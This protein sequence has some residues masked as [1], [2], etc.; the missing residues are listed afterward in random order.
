MTTSSA[1]IPSLEDPAGN[2]DALLRARAGLDGAEYVAWWTGDVY[3]QQPGADTRR[4]FGFVGFNVARAVA[5]DGGYDL[6]SREVAFYLD[7]RTRQIISRWHNPD[8]DSD[9]DV[10]HI[11]NDPVN[12]RFRLTMPWGPWRA[13]YTVLGRTVV[14]NLDIP[15]SAPSPL[16][17]SEWPDNS[18]DD[19]YRAMELFQFYAPRA[20]LLETDAPS[21]DCDISWVRTSPWLPWMRMGNRQGGLLF[22][23]R[24]SKLSGFDELPH[25]VRAY[26]DEQAP[27]YRHA[28]T[29]FTAPNESSWS[30]FKK[31]AQ[32]GRI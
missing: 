3:G 31:M 5:V 8:T 7:P 11:F 26:V 25:D 23:C 4:L 6:L 10:L 12:Q 13:P 30:Y 29:E 32:S 19:T 22:H 18:A 27:Q 17:V 21:V 28:P 9:V 14:F 2:L 15:I 1:P 24:G 20:A 16:P